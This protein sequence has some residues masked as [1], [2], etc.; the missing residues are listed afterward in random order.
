[1]YEPYGYEDN[2]N[3]ISKKDQIERELQQ[4]RI[5]DCK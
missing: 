1:M 5:N 2:S 3:Y 4:N